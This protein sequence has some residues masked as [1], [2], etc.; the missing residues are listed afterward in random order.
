MSEGWAPNECMLLHIG[1]TLARDASWGSYL[2]KILRPLAS[3]VVPSH[4]SAVLVP[5][6]L[7]D[8]RTAE[9]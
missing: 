2:S 3:K 8:V 7:Q 6:C 4:F 5:R 1:A 9:V